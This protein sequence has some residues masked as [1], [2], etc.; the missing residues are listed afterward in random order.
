MEPAPRERAR[1]ATEPFIMGAAE[2]FARLREWLL[3]VPY[4]E[5]AL[6]SRANVKSIG[7]L[8]SVDSGR[9]AFAKLDTV[10]SLLVQL[11]LDG[12]HISW[13]VVRDLLSPAELATL[14]DLGL[15]QSSFANAANCVG[16]IALI[17]TE[18]I[19]LASDRLTKMESV[20]DGLPPD[21]VYSPLTAESRGFVQMM[22]RVPCG[23][24]LEM[25]AGTGVAALLAAKHF[26]GHAYSADI[27]E[28]CTRFARFNAALNGLENFTAVQG[29]LY[30]PVKG[31]QFDVITAHPPYVPAESTEMIFRDGGADGEQITRGIIG[32]LPEY[33]KP[34]GLFYVHCMLTERSVDTIEQRLRRMLGPEEEEFDVLVFRGGS[35]DA[36]IHQAGQL[37]AGRISSAAHARQ[38][39][40]FTKVGIERFVDTHAIIQRRTT[41]RPV[42]TRRRALTDET[43]AEDLIWFTRY[44]SATVTWRTGNRHRLLDARPRAL[45]MTEL[46]VRSHLQGGAWTRTATTIATRAP[47]AAETACPEWF[48]DLL[49]R[50][51]GVSTAREH[52]ARLRAD[53]VV[54]PTTTDDDFADLIADLADAPYVELQ[55]FPIPNRD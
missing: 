29:D 54:P 5:A 35:L 6:C 45:P 17:P 34:G 16:T 40:Y 53:G 9:A 8:T 32:G 19:L 55:D 28:R 31:K 39:E 37:A 23:D 13:D 42:V 12:S 14:T 10:Q 27:T 1:W 18:S 20:G 24:Y 52:L 44:A 4:T 15:I 38:R 41:A 7:M 48:P 3:R 2:Q 25:C 51:N 11:F 43:R 26:A 47:F 33:L 50:C 30:E 22:P 36:K 21:L 49:R 46:S